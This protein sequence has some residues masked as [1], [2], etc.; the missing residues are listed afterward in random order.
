[1]LDNA[2]GKMESVNDL[3]KDTKDICAE[4]I[5]STKQSVKLGLNMK[6]IN[7]KKLKKAY[8]ELKNTAKSQPA[9]EEKQTVE[10]MT[11]LI[12]LFIDNYESMRNW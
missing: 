10:L 2:V 12:D 11:G 6:N 4:V 3:S 8:D 5:H 1:M 9:A 7:V